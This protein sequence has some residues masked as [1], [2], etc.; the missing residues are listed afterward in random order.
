MKTNLIKSSKT[1]RN[2]KANIWHDNLLSL[3]CFSK[4][5]SFSWFIMFW[6]KLK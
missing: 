3:K 6:S 2:G 4:M 1:E 5:L